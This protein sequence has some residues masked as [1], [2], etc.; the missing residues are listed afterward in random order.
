MH[1]ASWNEKNYH[2][3]NEHA[4]KVTHVF[5]YKCI[6]FS[7]HNKLH[8]QYLTYCG[9]WVSLRYF[10]MQSTNFVTVDNCCCCI[11]ND[12]EWKHISAHNLT[13]HFNVID[14]LWNSMFTL[15]SLKCVEMKLKL[16][17]FNNATL[18]RLIGIC[19]VHL[20]TMFCHPR[21]THTSLPRLALLH[22]TVVVLYLYTIKLACLHWL[23]LTRLLHCS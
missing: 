2:E 21:H 4:I 17:F 7:L 5:A 16:I 20:L 14:I 13:I 8:L 12:V 1:F 6:Y 9:I 15:Y 18:R 19:L 3:T 10:T 22:F 23:G 11:S